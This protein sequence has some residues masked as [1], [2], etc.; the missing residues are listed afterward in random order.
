VFVSALNRLAA[1][2]LAAPANSPEGAQGA[3]RP[4]QARK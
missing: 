4:R 2:H 3:R 1:G